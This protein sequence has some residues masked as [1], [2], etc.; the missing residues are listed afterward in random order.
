MTGSEAMNIH[1]S[2]NL[3]NPAVYSLA[4][5]IFKSTKNKPDSVAERVSPRVDEHF[6]ELKICT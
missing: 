6:S 4:C 5:E 2:L 3:S 1:V